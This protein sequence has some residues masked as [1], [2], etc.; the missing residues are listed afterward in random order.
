VIFFSA[1]PVLPLATKILMVALLVALAAYAVA[2]ER[3]KATSR[4]RAL[5]LALVGGI[6]LCIGLVMVLENMWPAPR[7]LSQTGMFWGG[8]FA[9]VCQ[10]SRLVGRRVLFVGLGV[11]M[12]SFIG[13]GNVILGDQLRTN[14]RDI[15]M[16]NRIVA[17][18]ESLPGFDKIEAM[19]ISGGRWAYASPVQTVQGDMNISALPVPWAKVPLLNEA[20]GYRFLEAPADVAERANAY[21]QGSAKWPALQ[22]VTKMGSTAVVC[23]AQ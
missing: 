10:F 4:M 3:K 1:E 15:E 9:L 22:S 20:T 23:L 21:C 14:M 16:A 2:S 13:I 5:G 12:F 18:I 8:M 11:M 7:V 6:P 19:A 17:R